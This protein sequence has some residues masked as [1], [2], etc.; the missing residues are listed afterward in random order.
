MVISN[1]LPVFKDENLAS[2]SEYIPKIKEHIRNSETSYPETTLLVYVISIEQ[3]LSQI[4]SGASL[5]PH[6]KKYVE[7]MINELLSEAESVSLGTAKMYFE[8]SIKNERNLV[9]DL[10]V[11]AYLEQPKASSKNSI[12]MILRILAKSS[13]CTWEQ[14]VVALDTLEI[15]ILH[16]DNTLL[17]ACLSKFLNFANND[18]FQ[19]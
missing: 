19:D 8:D 5:L 15:L 18:I 6:L 2:L 7:I 10:V 16:S 9:S 3:I 17:F 12:E 4:S 14:I 11:L 13:R 1:I